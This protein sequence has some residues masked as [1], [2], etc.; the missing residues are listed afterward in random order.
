LIWDECGV[1][2]MPLPMCAT[3][4]IMVQSYTLRVT[5]FTGASDLSSLI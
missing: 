4:L 5:D 1:G 3:A 2:A